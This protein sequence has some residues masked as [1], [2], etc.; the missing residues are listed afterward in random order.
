[1]IDCACP[2]IVEARHYTILAGSLKRIAQ[3]GLDRTQSRSMPMTQILGRN[4]R[5]VGLVFHVGQQGVNIVIPLL[6][7]ISDPGGYA[8]VFYAEVTDDLGELGPPQYGAYLAS[9]WYACYESFSVPADDKVVLKILEY[10]Q[11]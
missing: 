4:A 10:V 11:Q 3:V 9:A 2:A 1:M 5:R 6:S 8:N 7:T